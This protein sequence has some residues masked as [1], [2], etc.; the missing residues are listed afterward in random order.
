MQAM[1]N[2]MTSQDLDPNSVSPLRVDEGRPAAGDDTVAGRFAPWPAER[3]AE[4]LRL[5]GTMPIQD[6]A[7]RLGVTSNAVVGKL[8]RMRLRQDRPRTTSEERRRKRREQAARR[9]A[10]ARAH[11][12]TSAQDQDAQPAVHKQRQ[13]RPRVMAAAVAAPHR[14]VLIWDLTATSCRWPLFEGGDVDTQCY[15]GD[16]AAPGSPYCLMHH[17]RSR[18]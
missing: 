1:T 6:I 5:R 12:S 17:A 13:I 16:T 4:L 11:P 9:R 2:E 3:V 14:N 15:C 10:K 18:G 7:Q 8:S